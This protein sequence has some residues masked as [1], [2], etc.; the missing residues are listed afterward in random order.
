RS[1]NRPGV[2]RGISRTSRIQRAAP[3]ESR[4]GSWL[5]RVHR[6][7]VVLAAVT[8]RR[9]DGKLRHRGGVPRKGPR[10]V[11]ENDYLPGG[12]I[13]SVESRWVLRGPGARGSTL[14]RGQR[15]RTALSQ[16][17]DRRDAGGLMAR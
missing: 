3:K 6:L 15:G 4:Q 13:G 9:R 8:D 2:S 10:R 14:V 11:R 16:Q 1:R 17:A 5:D 7:P 12:R